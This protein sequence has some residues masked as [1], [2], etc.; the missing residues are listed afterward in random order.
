MILHERVF[1]LGK[2]KNERDFYFL[3]NWRPAEVVVFILG[4]QQPCFCAEFFQHEHGQDNL[5]RHD[6]AKR[7]IRYNRTGWSNEFAHE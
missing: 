7:N 6:A 3:A 1:N 2:K 4:F 5:K